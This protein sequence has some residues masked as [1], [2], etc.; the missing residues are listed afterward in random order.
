MASVRWL[1]VKVI[2]LVWLLTA[3]NSVSLNRLLKVPAGFSLKFVQ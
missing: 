2:V 1:I 3:H